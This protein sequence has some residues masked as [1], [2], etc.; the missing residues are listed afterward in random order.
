[1]GRADCIGEE[2]SST[3]ERQQTRKETGVA[4]KQQ[5]IGRCSAISRV[6]VVEGT[7]KV[8][9]ARAAT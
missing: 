4:E 5:D 3:H 2:L 8:A 6:G 7:S 1:M 9:P